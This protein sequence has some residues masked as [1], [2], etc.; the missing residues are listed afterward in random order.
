VLATFAP[1]STL[2]T[3][4]IA[5]TISTVSAV[6][7]GSTVSAVSALPAVSGT[8]LVPLFAL[9][10]CSFRTTI[11]RSS[12]AADGNS[13]AADGNSTAAD[14]N[15][16]AADGNSTAANGNSTAACRGQCSIYTVA[17]ARRLCVRRIT[18]GLFAKRLLRDPNRED[19]A[20][21]RLSQ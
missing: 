1:M 10:N 6:S 17:A 8:L 14:G 3:S 5:A 7:C 12:A 16:T 21:Q 13:T 15:S 20:A 18:L 2:N 4:T 11:A 9:C 19:L